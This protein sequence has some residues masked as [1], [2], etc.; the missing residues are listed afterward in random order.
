M[1]TQVITFKDWRFFKDMSVEIAY[2]F[3][4]VYSKKTIVDTINVNY[5]STVDQLFVYVFFKIL[6]CL[7][8]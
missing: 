3:P 6:L 1:F 8:L 7:K 5:V 4:M 2:L